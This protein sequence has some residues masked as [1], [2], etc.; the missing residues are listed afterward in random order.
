MVICVVGQ[1]KNRLGQEANPGVSHVL[2]RFIH[3]HYYL[4][5]FNKTMS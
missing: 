4:D 5:L 3:A 1:E 2:K